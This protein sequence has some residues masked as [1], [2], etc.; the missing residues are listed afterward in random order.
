[1]K[2]DMTKLCYVHRKDLWPQTFVSINVE[3]RQF[4]SGLQGRC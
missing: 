3:K 1:M 4:S 2:R